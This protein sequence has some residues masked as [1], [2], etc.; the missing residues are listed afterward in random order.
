[1]PSV[2]YS[3]WPLGCVCQAV[4]AP[5]V[6]RTCAQPTHD[7]SSGLRIVSMKT[8][9]VNHASGPEAVWPPLLVNFMLFVLLS[10]AE[11]DECLDRPAFVHGGIGVMTWVR[12]QSRA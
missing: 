7:C 10:L 1:M 9:P 4:R 8:V 3:V 5:G 11:L 12:P 6:N 2:T